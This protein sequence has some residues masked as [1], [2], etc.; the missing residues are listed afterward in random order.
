MSETGQNFCAKPAILPN[1]FWYTA[2]DKKIT[3]EPRLPPP[4]DIIIP[5][6][7]IPS[8]SKNHIVSNAKY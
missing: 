5:L 7:N 2:P 1:L 6:K 8:D 4:K 3:I